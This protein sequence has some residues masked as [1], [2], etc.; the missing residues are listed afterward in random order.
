MRSV[1]RN[2]AQFCGTH[3]FSAL[4]NTQIWAVLLLAASLQQGPA[5]GR[6]ASG[7]GARGKEVMGTPGR[8]VARGG[9]VCYNEVQLNIA[10]Y[11]CLR[12]QE[13]GRA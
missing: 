1:T 3:E 7:R 13:F 11:R 5:Y 2:E 12:L 8:A 6:T 4:S 10:D 9:Q